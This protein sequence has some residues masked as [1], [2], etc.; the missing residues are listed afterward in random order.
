MTTKKICLG[1]IVGVHGIRGELKVK[2]FTACDR[3]I[4]NYGALED[5]DSKQQF[6]LKVTGHSKDLLRI[7]IKGIDDRTLAETLIGTELYAPRGVFPVLKDEE[8]YYEADLVG[9][10]VYD[11]NKNTVAKVAGFYNFGAGDILE[12]KLITGRQ[13]MIPF[14]KSY[15]PSINLEEGYIIVSST[16]MVF[17]EDEEDSNEC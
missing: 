8:T 7:K 2:S 10:K 5:K 12:L 4:A 11:E 6:E 9:L 14:N 17:L 13:E 16:G 1:K 3:D 15:V